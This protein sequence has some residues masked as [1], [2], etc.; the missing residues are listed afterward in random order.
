MSWH[1]R[2]NTITPLI[3]G[4][5]Q[6]GVANSTVKDFDDNIALQR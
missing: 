6:I 5:V 1:D 3:P 2:E 4:L